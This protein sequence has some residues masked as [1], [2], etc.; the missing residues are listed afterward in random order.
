MI[1]FD[2]PELSPILDGLQAADP[3]AYAE[4]LAIIGSGRAML[5]EKPRAD[6]PGFVPCGT[7]RDR[8][9]KYDKLRSQQL[10]VRAAIAA[11]AKI[12]ER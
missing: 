8:K 11:G 2:R 9:A 5:E 7:D 3:L 10:K 4:V 6:M 12:Y 1:S